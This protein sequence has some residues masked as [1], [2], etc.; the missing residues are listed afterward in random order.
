MAEPPPAKRMDIT[1]EEERAKP[2]VI[3]QIN[4]RRARKY[5][6]EEVTFRAK[7][8]D[9]LQGRKLLD[10]MDDLGD[11][12]GSIMTNVRANHPN[13]EDKARLSIKHAG[14]DREITIHCQPQHNITPEVIM[15]R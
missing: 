2:F 13:H 11:M 3:E 6:V 1:A 15:E 4:E 12:F 7:F 5:G 14:L 8:N 10:V 9:D